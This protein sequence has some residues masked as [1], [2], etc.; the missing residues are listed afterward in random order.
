VSVCVEG[1]EDGSGCEKQ[2]LDK[3]EQEMEGHCLTVYL[4]VLQR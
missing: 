3:V 1:G 4:S 2:I